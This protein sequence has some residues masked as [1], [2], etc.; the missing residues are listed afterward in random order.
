MDSQ[1]SMLHKTVLSSA[2]ITALLLGATPGSARAS[3]WE[4]AQHQNTYACFV[5]DGGGWTQCTPYLDHCDISGQCHSSKTVAALPGEAKTA[6][7]VTCT[8]ADQ[9]A[10]TGPH[11]SYTAADIAAARSTDARVFLD[12]L[13][14]GESNDTKAA[15]LQTIL[16]GE[17]ADP[18]WSKDAS[19]AIAEGLA[20]MPDGMNL[21]LSLLET[22][23]GT[24]LCEVRAVGMHLT[25]QQVSQDQTTWSKHVQALNDSD[26]FAH[27][28]LDPALNTNL[29]GTTPDGRP[30]FVSFFVRNPAKG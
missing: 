1:R 20:Q 24:T 18:A 13:T 6:A 5:N 11:P 30:L 8:P 27:I 23:C 22:S 16:N 25:D 28:K 4:C 7:E 9:A 29:I 10:V 15:Q 3:C 17:K 19:A 26:D 2:C 21:R 12:R 14:A